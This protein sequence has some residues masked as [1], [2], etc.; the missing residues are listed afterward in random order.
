MCETLVAVPPATKIFGKDAVVRFGKNSDRVTR[1]A[2]RDRRGWL[3]R[4]YWLQQ[5]EADHLPYNR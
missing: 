1:E 5:N 4:R 2:N 3:T